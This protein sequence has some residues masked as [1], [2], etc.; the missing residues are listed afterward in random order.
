MTLNSKRGVMHL[1]RRTPSGWRELRWQTVSIVFQGA[2]NA[3]DPIM[4]I[5]RQIAEA[6]RLHEPEADATRGSASCSSASA[7]RARA[8]RSTRTSSRAA[9]ASA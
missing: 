4:R 6:I 5:D 8:A 2:M 7:S 3:L 9:C 1:Q